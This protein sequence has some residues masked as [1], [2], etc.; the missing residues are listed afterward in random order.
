MNRNWQIILDNEDL[1]YIHESLNKH[2]FAFNI[3]QRAKQME[4]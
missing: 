4:I 3:E 2:C 1:I